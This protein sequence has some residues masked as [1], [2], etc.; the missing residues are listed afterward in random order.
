M[1]KEQTDIRGIERLE[2]D[3]KTHRSV[4]DAAE[5]HSNLSGL[6]LKGPIPVAWLARA[7]EL[8]LPAL[9]V[10]LELWLLS[11]LRRSNTVDLN[12]SR[13]RFTDVRAR[14]SNQRGLKR[15]EDAGLVR[16]RRHPGRRSQVEIVAEDV[17][18]TERLTLGQPRAH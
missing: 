2:W 10:G 13:F 6:F 12:L 3:G 7:A 16:V 8:G 5:A 18:R 4:A 17:R 11:G 1:A 14:Q 15:L 9:V